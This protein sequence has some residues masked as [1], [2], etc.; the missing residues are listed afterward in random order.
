MIT[1]SSTFDADPLIARHQPSLIQLTS[2]TWMF[3]REGHT[4][5]DFADLYLY[6]TRPAATR[7]YSEAG[8]PKNL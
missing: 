6:A 8:N 1:S 2:H 5:V 4:G 7:R 3:Q